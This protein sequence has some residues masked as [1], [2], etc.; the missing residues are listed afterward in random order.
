[1]LWT[2]HVPTY[3]EFQIWVDPFL[4]MLMGFVCFMHFLNCNNCPVDEDWVISVEIYG[5]INPFAYF[6]PE[7]KKRKEITSYTSHF[8]SQ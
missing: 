6:N 3:H 8:F 7:K 1:M 2:V 5:L 4:G